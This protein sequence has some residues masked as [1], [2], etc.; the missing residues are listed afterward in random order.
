[1]KTVMFIIMLI[2]TLF[3]ENASLKKA[4]LANFKLAYSTGKELK[5]PDGDDLALTLDNV[6]KERA[7]EF[8]GENIRKY[9]LERWGELKSAI[10]KSK[11]NLAALRDGIGAYASVPANIYYKY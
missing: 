2:S 7:F 3:A 1:M 6:K 5:L 11:S 4:Q 9:D 10:D 8:C